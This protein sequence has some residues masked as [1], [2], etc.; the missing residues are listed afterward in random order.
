MAEADGQPPVDPQTLGRLV[1]AG[2]DPGEAITWADRAEGVWMWLGQELG[3]TTTLGGAAFAHALPVLWGLVVG[4]ALTALG[5]WLR[6]R[7]GG[8]ERPLPDTG[9]TLQAAPRVDADADFEA[10]AQLTDPDA[11]LAASWTHVDR[12]LAAHLKR[13]THP[14]LSPLELVAQVPVALRS[15][16]DPL[17]RTYVAHRYRPGVPSLAAARSFH[18][19]VG[20]WARS[21][22]PTE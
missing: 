13:P 6:G 4:L 2:I 5:M 18:G 17:A 21:L 7:R 3:G 8:L 20:A 15:T 12:V 19:T 9:T 10:A 22:R 1:D 16:V 14:E 11:L